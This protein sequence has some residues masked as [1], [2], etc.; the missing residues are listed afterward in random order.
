MLLCDSVERAEAQIVVHR[1]REV[2]EFTVPSAAASSKQAPPHQP[3]KQRAHPAARWRRIGQALVN[4][5]CS[6]SAGGI[7]DVH[8]RTLPGAEIIVLDR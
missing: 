3:A 5:P 1:D 4:L 2:E 7:N 6:S 8:N